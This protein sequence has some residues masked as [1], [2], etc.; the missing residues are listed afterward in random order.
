MNGVVDRAIL[1]LYSF[2]NI[3]YSSKI[4]TFNMDAILIHSQFI[5]NNALELPDLRVSILRQMYVFTVKYVS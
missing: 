3:G 2:T 4:S 5:I 1:L